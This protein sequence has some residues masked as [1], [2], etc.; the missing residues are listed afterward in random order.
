MNPIKP[1]YSVLSKIVL[2]LSPADA[3]STQQPFEG[4]WPLNIPP[5]RSFFSID[6]IVVSLT[7]SGTQSLRVI[8]L[9]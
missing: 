7:W 1:G 5:C 2:P 4:Q 3:M 6:Y 9:E 8:C